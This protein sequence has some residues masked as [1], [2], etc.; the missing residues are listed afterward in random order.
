MH[1]KALRQGMA[2]CHVIEWG[3][4]IQSVPRN[5]Y[6]QEGMQYVRVYFG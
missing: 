5:V 4:I 6:S 3:F 2:A 1:I